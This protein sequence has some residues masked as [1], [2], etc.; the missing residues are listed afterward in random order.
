LAIRIAGVDKVYYERKRNHTHRKMLIALHVSLNKH[1][2]RLADLR[3]TLSQPTTES[4]PNYVQ[5]K[6]IYTEYETIIK[7]L[8][9]HYEH[10]VKHYELL[11]N[12]KFNY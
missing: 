12:E 4:L 11:F 2:A 7:I 6:V 3:E 5:L 10:S 8:E 1:K 9:Y